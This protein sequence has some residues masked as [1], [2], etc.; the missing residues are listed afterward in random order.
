MPRR[1]T[2]LFVG[3]G[4][5]GHIFPNLAIQER[6]VET[7]AALFRSQ[8]VVSERSLDAKILND[9]GESFEALAV[10]PLTSRFWK[11]PSFWMNWMK[12][13]RSMRGRINPDEV[14]AVVATGGFVSGPPVIAASRAGVPVALVNL[15]AIPGKANRMLARHVAKVFT[16]YDVPRWPHA[17][18]IGLPLRRSALGPGRPS[19][20]RA[21]LGL[22][23]DR[24][25]LLVVGGSQGATSL[26][27]MMPLLCSRLRAGLASWQVLHCAGGGAGEVEAVAKA[28]EVS[29]VVARVVAFCDPLG[30]AWDAATVA[31]ARAGAGGVAEA[32]ANHVPTV[33][34]P[35]P[36]HRDQHQ[37]HNVEPLIRAGGCLRFED[38]IDPERNAAALAGPVNELIQH[39]ATRESMQ[40]RMAEN[41]RE[42]GA[43]VL[44]AWLAEQSPP[45]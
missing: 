42:D 34:L 19:R 17:R 27:R 30:L 9:L 26:N 45:P 12:S 7:D 15:D 6:L 39:Q 25:T 14:V 24:E 2:I 35:Y 23:A 11:W 36:H 21:E 43:A 40:R 44:A 8:F 5:G 38:L 16:V 33:F 3:G 28:Y 13:A 22:D 18:R 10:Q 41:Q 29:G 32:W 31:I 20:S 37:H 1:R 4:T